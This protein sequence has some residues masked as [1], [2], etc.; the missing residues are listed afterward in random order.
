[1]ACEI[2]VES[3]SG[4][5]DVVAEIDDDRLVA[6]DFAH[7]VVEVACG[8]LEGDT[9]FSGLVRLDDGRLLRVLFALVVEEDEFAALYGREGAAD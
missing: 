2:H 4:D 3:D 6:F 7:G 1:M 8:G 9:D 5:I